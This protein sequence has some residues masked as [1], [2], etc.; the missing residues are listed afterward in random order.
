MQAKGWL[1]DLLIFQDLSYMYS[2]QIN[3]DLLRSEF[4]LMPINKDLLGIYRHA[5]FPVLTI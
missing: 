1:Y 5:P 4:I 3:A 2:V